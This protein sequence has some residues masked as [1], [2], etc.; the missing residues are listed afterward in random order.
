MSRMARSGH[1][2]LRN[3]IKYWDGSGRLR[4]FFELLHGKADGHAQ[5]WS[6]NGDVV[7]DEVYRQ[8]KLLKAKVRGPK[9]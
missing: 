8:S 3:G 1:Y 7:R 9:L 5:E 4:S 6:E 2:E